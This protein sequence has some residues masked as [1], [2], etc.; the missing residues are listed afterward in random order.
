MSKLFS[1]INLGPHALSHR[2]VAAPVTRL[3]SEAG[4]VPGDL[5]VEN[6]AQRAS[7]GGFI[8]AEASSVSLTGIGY[9]GAPGIY[10]DAQIAG[11]KKVT[12]AVH[13]KGAIIYLQLFH[14]GRASHNDLQPGGLAPVAPSAIQSEGFAFTENGWVPTAKPRALEIAEIESI[15]EDFRRGAERA[16]AAGFDGVELHSL[17][18]YLHDEFLQD[19]SNKRTDLYGGSLENRT[20]FLLK[21]VDGLVAVWGADRVAV[22]IGP[23]GEFGSMFDSNPEATFAYVAEKL[24]AYGLAYLHIVEPRIKGD[25]QPSEAAPVASAQLRKIFKGT[26]IAAG[27]FK[28]DSAEAIIERGDADL[29]A[30]G[31]DFI[32]TPDLPERMRL[33]LPLNAYD[34]ASFYGGDARGYNDYPFYDQ[35]AA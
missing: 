33:N 3:R 24:N 25:D 19:G 18:G 9:L 21:V 31:R 26:I 17:N 34:R 10:D 28:R 30:F 14:C 27:G 12:D 5:M 16:L 29:V 11:W 35:A 15:T 2:V 13:A 6:Y 20:R 4:D 22:R 32:A 8:I 7:K 1:A 23:S